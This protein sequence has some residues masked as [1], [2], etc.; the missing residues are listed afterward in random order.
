MTINVVLV[1]DQAMVHASFRMILDSR[2]DIDVVAE[3]SDGDG[4]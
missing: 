2:G 4:A 3:A 1:D